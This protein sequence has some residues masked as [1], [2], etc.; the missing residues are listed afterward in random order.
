MNVV[1]CFIEALQIFSQ[2][3][4]Y[5]VAYMFCTILLDFS[6][7]IF[8]SFHQWYLKIYVFILY[9]RQLHELPHFSTVL[10]WFCF[11]V[12]AC[13]HN[14][15]A[16]FSSIQVLVYKKKKTRRIPHLRCWSP[17]SVCLLFIFQNIFMSFLHMTSRINCA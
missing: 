2:M 11:L 12:C 15:D 4:L 9:M 3:F 17:Q 13:W 5:I 14:Q 1:Y 7:L 16:S 6:Y 10:H 8:L